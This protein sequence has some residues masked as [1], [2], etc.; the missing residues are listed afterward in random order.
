MA[1][2]PFAK[3]MSIGSPPEGDHQFSIRAG[4]NRRERTVKA[5]VLVDDHVAQLGDAAT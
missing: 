4:D 2:A 1:G 3:Y 5:C